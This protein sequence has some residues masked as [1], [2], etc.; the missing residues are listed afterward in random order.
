MQQK[1]AWGYL[2]TKHC[3]M[4]RI[5]SVLFIA[6]LGLLAATSAQSQMKIGY[7]STQDL[8]SVMP[9]TKIADSNLTQLQNALI[10]NAQEKEAKLN[11]D[12]E[13]F[14]KDSGSMS[15]AVKSVK[16]QDLQKLYH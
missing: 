8:I 13:K 12:I 2:K 3:N 16:R 9:E 4:K 15:E 10:Q 6:A 1:K 5:F 7:I 11:A 14:N